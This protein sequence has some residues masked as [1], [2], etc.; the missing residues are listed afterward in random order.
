MDKNS[1]QSSYFLTLE[2]IEGSGKTTQIKLLEEYFKAEG[3]EVTCLREPGGTSLGEE[4]RNLI[5]NAKEK[6]TPLTELYLFAASRAHLLTTKILPILEKTKQ[7][8]IVD[9]YFDSTIAYQ[10]M[11]RELGPKAVIHAHSLF[12]LTRMPDL[13]FYLKI[14]LETSKTRQLKRGNEKDYFEKEN[15]AFYKKLLEG[16]DYSS[17]NFPER[18]RVINAEEDQTRVYNSIIEIVKKE[19]MNA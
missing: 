4:L 12:P 18:F 6:I 7:I 14:S 19:I 5:L 1:T 3:Y 15:D 17:R 9:R 2:G 11:A 10:G 16:F 8:V 13:T